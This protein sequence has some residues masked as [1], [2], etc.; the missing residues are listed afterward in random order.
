MPDHERHETHGSA[1]IVDCTEASML[2]TARGCH[3]EPFFS[4][5]GVFRGKLLN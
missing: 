4:E 3:L 2:T 5:F 1:I